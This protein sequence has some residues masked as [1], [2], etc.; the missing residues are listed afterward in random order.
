METDTQGVMRLLT[1][2]PLQKLSI[3]YNYPLK[4]LNSEQTLCC[5]LR[6]VYMRAPAQSCLTLCSGSSVHRIFQAKILEWVAIS[7]SR[8]SSW[9]RDW[10][11]VSCLGRHILYH[12]TTWEA[13]VSIWLLTI[14]WN[15]N[16]K[17]IMVFIIGKR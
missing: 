2:C 10:T 1:S 11:S 8:G 17:A 12:C 5:P 6:L 13:P 9:P 7:S 3:S 14:F 4:Q 15:W 16:F